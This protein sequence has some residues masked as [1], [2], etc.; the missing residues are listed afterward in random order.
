MTLPELKALA[1]LL[2]E[3]PPSFLTDEDYKLLLGL[4]QRELG[5]WREV[6]PETKYTGPGEDSE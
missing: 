4:V 6:Y 5:N 1:Q 3:T 2:A